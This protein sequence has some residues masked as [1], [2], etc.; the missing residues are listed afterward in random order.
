MRQ[1]G[2]NRGGAEGGGGIR[3]KSQKRRQERWERRGK[4]AVRLEGR[5]GA[6]GREE[7]KGWAWGSPWT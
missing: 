4:R 1:R 5:I 2:E 3:A 7:E 6:V